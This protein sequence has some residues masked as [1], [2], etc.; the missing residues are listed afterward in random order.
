MKILHTKLD[1][2]YRIENF[3]SSD[4]R[5]SF[6]KVFNYTEFAKN[7][8][9]TEFKEIYYSN[10][11]R[12]VIRGMHFQIPPFDHEKLVHVIRGSVLDVVVDLRKKSPTY[13]EYITFELNEGN[14]NSIYIPKGFAH[15]FRA[16]EDF[17]TMLYCVAEVYNK[18][19]DEGIRWD[20]IGLDW[21]TDNP[22]LSDRDKGFCVLSQFASPF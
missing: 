7:E 13:G 11:Y 22:I 8:L 17:T 10:S 12:D 19:S 21:N 5:G 3:F 6:N 1:G 14:A 16:L 18:E 15:G 20:S 9:Q 4:Q 2:V